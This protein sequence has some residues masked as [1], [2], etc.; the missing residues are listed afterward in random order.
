MILSYAVRRTPQA[1][2]VGRAANLARTTTALSSA[3]ST[4]ADLR[5]C[6]MSAAYS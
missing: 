5:G 3:A 4:P 2:F 6:R 1:S